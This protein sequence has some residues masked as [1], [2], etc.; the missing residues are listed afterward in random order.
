L[1]MRS[2]RCSSSL[3]RWWMAASAGCRRPT[4]GSRYSIVVLRPI[5]C[6]LGGVASPTLPAIVRMFST[7]GLRL[8]PTSKSS[9]NATDGCSPLPL[10]NRLPVRVL[11]RIRRDC[12]SPRPTCTLPLPAELPPIETWLGLTYES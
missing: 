4:D 1:S 7:F 3:S 11:R 10:A 12:G 8:M 6:L 2:I 9:L 5:R